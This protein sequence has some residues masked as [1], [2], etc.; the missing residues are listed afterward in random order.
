[1]K[2]SI[3]F[4]IVK[5]LLFT[6]IVFLLVEFA[7]QIALSVLFSS[8]ENT[9]FIEGFLDISELIWKR[10]GE[11][12]IY[13]TDMIRI[14]CFLVL[15]MP[16]S[17]CIMRMIDTQVVKPLKDIASEMQ[18][19]DTSGLNNRIT[20]PTKCEYT[21][22][23]AAFNKVMDR[24]E[25]ADKQR[26]MLITGM[27]HD[28]KT[29]ITTMKGYSQ[30]LIEGVVTEE[31]QR[32]EYLL[33]IHR[34]SVQLDELVSILFDYAK[35]MTLQE[36]PK[37]EQ[38]DLIELIKENIGLFYTDF[39]E[40]KIDFTFKLPEESVYIQGDS[41]QLERVFS[42]IYANALKHNKEGDSV[43]TEI[44]LNHGIV[45]YIRDTGVRIPE[46]I[47]KHIFEPFVIGDSSRKNNGSGLGLSIASK[48]M[49][50]HHGKIM[51]EQKEDSQYS[52]S[53]VIC[54]PFT[55]K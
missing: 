10:S 25:M 1:M 40:K 44:E 43:C 27:A 49:E 20:I 34:K 31:G 12:N 8:C 17:I 30:A 39:E 2:N 16:Y 55:R 11:L 18:N 3:R 21:E 38:I 54:F 37:L 35:L 29:P 22:V 23:K 6:T 28:L 47:E 14:G 33:A 46:N 50:L 45:V 36:I 53:F 19:M 4:H 48:I 52:K 15:I 24:L 42:N 41:K 26:N 5:G 13:Y 32:K 7:V 9:S 51:L